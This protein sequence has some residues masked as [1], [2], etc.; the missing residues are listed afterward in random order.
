MSIEK[1]P[2]ML[3]TYGS[4]S[5][6]TDTM[7]V[8]GSSEDAGPSA[9]KGSESEASTGVTTGAEAETPL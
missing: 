6:R 3:T 7:V 5:E 4:K 1:R 8:K 9:E 2:T